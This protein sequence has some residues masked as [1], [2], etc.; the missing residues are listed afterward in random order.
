MKRFRI[1]L[2]GGGLIDCDDCFFRILYLPKVYSSEQVRLWGL[3]CR[4]LPVWE[5]ESCCRNAVEQE[6]KCPWK[7]CHSM[8]RPTFEAYCCCNKPILCAHVC[9][10]VLSATCILG[11]CQRLRKS[12][13]PILTN[14]LKNYRSYLGSLELTFLVQQKHSDPSRKCWDGICVSFWSSSLGLISSSVPPGH[15][16]TY[17]LKAGVKKRKSFVVPVG[18]RPFSTELWV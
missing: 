11:W 6:E 17:A 5:K 14:T 18:D 12:W 1:F 15:L 10:W 13:C 2:E 8:F 3:P 9:F 16:N 7:C 4:V